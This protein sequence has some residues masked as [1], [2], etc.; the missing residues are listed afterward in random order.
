MDTAG[1]RPL[2]LGRVPGRDEQHNRCSE[3]KTILALDRSWR[4]GEGWGG[5]CGMV[6][7]QHPVKPDPS[8]LGRPGRPGCDTQLLMPPRISSTPRFRSWIVPGFPHRHLVRHC[9]P[10]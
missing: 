2:T 3:R 7:V 1:S 4:R 6:W 9:S 10:S 5:R 8:E